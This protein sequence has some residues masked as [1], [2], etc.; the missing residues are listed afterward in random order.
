MFQ[1]IQKVKLVFGAG[2][3][4]DLGVLLRDG[5]FSRAFIVCDLGTV[6]AGLVG[7]VEASLTDAGLTAYVYDKVVPEPTHTVSE[8]GI[9]LF[10]EQKCDVVI[11]VG[12]G[13][14]LDSAK[15]VNILRFNEGSILRFAGANALMNPAP[16]LYLVPTTSGT[17]SELSDGLVMSGDDGVKHGILATDAMAECAFLDPELLVTM[18]RTITLTT[19]L[20]A[21][22][23]ACEGYMTTLSTPISD[24]MAEKTMQ[25]IIKWLPLALRDGQNIE[26][27][28][29]MAVASTMAGWMLQ[30][31]HTNAGH[32]IAHI[33][34][35]F[36]GIPHG[37]A[38]AYATPWVLEFNAAAVPQKVKEVGVLLGAAFTGDETPEEIGRLTR[39]AYLRYCDEELQLLPASSYAVDRALFSQMAEEITHELFQVFQLRPMSKNNAH[40]ILKKIFPCA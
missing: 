1:L 39:E 10:N 16:N 15:A 8:E 19:G 20:D 30:Y 34:T 35:S 21:F 11:G 18:P 38:C 36:L 28:S 5:G 9:R 14:S 6:A 37:A 32:S 2:C 7:K 17:G 31:S 27:R 33:V 24:F 23:H 4:K 25:T 29:N 12:G 22:S 40:E 13:S 3:I 26:A